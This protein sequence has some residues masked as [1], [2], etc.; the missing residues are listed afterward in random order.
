MATGLTTYVFP[1]DPEAIGEGGF[2]ASGLGAVR[3]VDGLT[4]FTE[5]KH[6][7]FDSNPTLW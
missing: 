1:P 6:L 7:N 4:A 5:T 3:G 2:K